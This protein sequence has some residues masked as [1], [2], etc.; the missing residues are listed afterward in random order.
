LLRGEIQGFTYL[1]ESTEFQVLVGDQKIQA[2]GEPA[3]ALRRG[4]SVYLRIPVGD[5][6]LIR[7]GEV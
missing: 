2:K 4:A 6:L 3:Q 5:C 7:Q 1:G